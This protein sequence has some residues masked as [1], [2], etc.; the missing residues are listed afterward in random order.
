MSKDLSPIQRSLLVIEK[1]K[2]KL[3]AVEDAST[4]PIA[5][6]GM[7]CRFP[8]GAISPEA[9]WELLK[10]GF[11]AI[12][13]VPEQRWNVPASY[14][15]DPQVAGKTYSKY[16]GFLD[17]VEYFDPQ[18]FGISPREAISLDPQHRL[19]LEVSWEALENAAYDMKDLR[20]SKTGVFIGITLNDYEKV[21]SGHQ[22]A[23]NI[24]PYSVTGLP[25]NAAA[26]RLSYSYG[27]TG[28]SMA[29]DTACSSSLVAIHQACQSLRVGDC[30]MAL[31]GGVNLILTPQ[32]MIGTAKA[33]M[34]S[35]DGYCKTFDDD[36]DGIGRSEGCGIIVL[37]R[38]SDAD[39]DGDT[40]LAIIRGSA[41]NQDGASSG[42]TVPNS[43]AQQ[44]LMH[45][46]LEMAKLRPHEIDYVEAHGTGTSLGDPIE[47]RSLAGVFGDDPNRA[48]P[49]K[50]GSVKTN[51]GHAESASGI[52]GV[53]KAVL[54]LKHKIVVPHLHFN[55]PTTKFDWNGF[56]AEVPIE[57]SEWKQEDR[58][59]ISG[60]SSFGASGTNGHIIVAEAPSQTPS[61]RKVLSGQH[62][63]LLTLSAKDEGALV[64][65]VERYQ[66]YLL[67]DQEADLAA[68]CYTATVGRTTFQY[69]LG[70]VGNSKQQ[71]AEK[72]VTAKAV[73]K[74]SYHDKVA[75]LFTGQGTQYIN[76]G[77]D[78]YENYPVFK[79]S[80][81][82]CEELLMPYLEHRL[83][84]ILFPS[85]EGKENANRLLNTTAYAQPA[86]VAIQYALNELWKSWGVEPTMVMGHSVGEYA[87]AT[88]AGVMTIEDCM[89]L[90]AMRGKLMQA[91]PLGGTMIAVNIAEHAVRNYIEHDVA[92]AA[93]NGAD[94]LVISGNNSSLEI[95]AQRLQ[96][97]GYTV[98][99]LN[100]SHAF[101]SPLMQPMLAEF[102]SFAKTKS[103]HEP[104][105]SIISNVSGKRSG[106]EMATASYWVDHVMQPVL[107][108]DGLAS[109]IAE[110]YEI[111]VELGPKPV[112]SGLGKESYSGHKH[113]Q[114]L[115]SLK[116]TDHGQ[117]Q[118]L[119]SLGELY[120]L[121][122]VDKVKSLFN[123]QIAKVRLPNYPFQR[124]YCWVQSTKTQNHEHHFY[125][126]DTAQTFIGNRIYQSGSR[127][128]YFQAAWSA[129][130]PN[131][132][133]DH[134]IFDKTVVAGASHVGMMLSAFKEVSNDEV[135]HLEDIYLTEALAFNQTDKRLVEIM[136]DNTDNNAANVSIYSY[137]M[138]D[139]GNGKT[140]RRTHVNGKMFFGR[141]PRDASYALLQ[142]LKLD[143]IRSRCLNTISGDDFYQAMWN[144][145][146][147]LGT[148]FRWIRQIWQR[149]GEALC[150]LEVPALPGFANEIKD[151]VL[152]PGLIDSCLQMVGITAD[153]DKIK[154][155]ESEDYIFAPF[156]IEKFILSKNT[157]EESLWC[158]CVINKER[159]NELVLASDIALV[160]AKGEKV[161]EIIGF[162]TRK[163]PKTVLHKSLNA[164]QHRNFHEIKWINSSNQYVQDP[165]YNQKQKWLIYTDNYPFANEVAMALR[166]DAVECVLA[167]QG[168]N[169]E[170]NEGGV[171][172]DLLQV[173]EIFKI[174]KDIN[175]VIILANNT[176][177]TLTKESIHHAQRFF[178]SAMNFIQVALKHCTG[179]DAAIF[180]A[181]AGTQYVDASDLILP[182]YAP[183]WGIGKVLAIEHPELRCRLIDLDSEAQIKTQQ[184]ALISELKNFDN[185]MQV[186]YRNGARFVSRV[187][188][189]EP[190]EVATDLKGDIKADS[191][192]LITGG[193]G[194]L[195]LEFAAWLVRQ[196]AA[197]LVL[198]GRSEP[199][200]EAKSA[201]DQLIHLGANV[202][203]FS[204]DISNEKQCVD[205]INTLTA[206]AMPSLRGIIHAA[207]VLEDAP[208]EQM[209]KERFLKVIE[210]KISG[211]WNLH[212]HTRHLKLDF[213]VC[214]SS[215]SSFLG[216]HYQSNYAAGNAFMDALVNYR[217][218]QGLPGL[219][220]NWGP[221]DKVGMAARMGE[222]YKAYL[223]KSGVNLIDPIAGTQGLAQL[224]ATSKTNIGFM[225]IDWDR[226]EHY[227][228]LL[229]RVKTVPEQDR[230]ETG[231]YL[232]LLEDLTDEKRAAVI[233][234]IVSKEIAKVLGADSTKI[235]R[236]AS[237][238][239]IGIDS[240]MAVEIRTIVQKKLRVDI[241]VGKLLEGGSIID[242]AEAITDNMEKWKME[243]VVGS[244]EKR[245]SLTGIQNEAFVEGEL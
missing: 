176:P 196:G 146:Y 155:M 27:F 36:A 108:A 73:R 83:T 154:K 199:S 226:Y 48:H 174:N 217:R 11:D 171:Y 243:V 182:T 230:G 79:R 58:V 214:F 240:L 113:V 24:E 126:R 190:R 235:D 129:S 14:D 85:A 211:T 77:K 60:V 119:T 96:Q 152:H 5:I 130:N 7:S 186:A 49:L 169:A 180:I 177:G 227:G 37:K 194:A 51:I 118:I 128:I 162:E 74:A 135:Y 234:E 70:V 82:Y 157:V 131:Y 55:K 26:G 137:K 31:A 64:D 104:N 1:L 153:Y 207:G 56:Q 149:P 3:K 101:H 45:S 12:T 140:D 76:M 57:S 16:G 47:L 209:G 236:Q 245:Q 212:Q 4:E 237:L 116:A 41:V 8:G 28:P 68:I 103:F 222:K 216:T 30:H 15:P 239:A 78:L 220:V 6:I 221:W 71:L 191:N 46:A 197:N 151:Y 158:Y 156:H 200:T 145:D 20:G 86:I 110:G 9:Y 99:T 40:V 124:Q 105:I 66:S 241:P 219:S 138:A 224:L 208:I 242:L 91:L 183:L 223:E 53:M 52:A 167:T 92:I 166:E 144:A 94:S 35:P 178:V 90:I 106:S 147:H 173:E 204:T 225:D 33:K 50:I 231:D 59:R 159:S 19:L 67:N 93:V 109:T 229:D 22:A 175:R 163:A 114:W 187:E 84:A 98:S 69:R 54:Q 89:P 232:N 13:E 120:M 100:V 141:S 122:V 238:F 125:H 25:L 87:A 102:E 75:F 97:D 2:S 202:C 142:E 29:I 95:I 132:V 179:K 21:I 181:T 150:A 32:S 42:F 168:D 107:F 63:Y 80:I 61:D 213:F 195:G 10:N 72:L 192:Y 164:T 121:G 205:L 148:S 39:K 143:E 228:P 210:P 172:S 203:V 23:N 201:I 206:P 134:I 193:L 117:Q 160:N 17:N 38:L 198:V 123:Q 18:F 185:E 136:L 62:F 215:L 65:L 81:D 244:K 115:P 184:E 111:F 189:F 218:A 161:V 188:K 170:D 233:I 127:N 133:A 34:L 165:S 88:V 43:Q 112:L 139:N 44:A